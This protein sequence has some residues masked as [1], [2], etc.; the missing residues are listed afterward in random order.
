MNKF[1]EKFNLILE[2]LN[3]KRYDRIN[4]NELFKTLP[5]K[6]QSF[7]KD[8]VDKIFGGCSYRTEERINDKIVEL[9]EEDPINAI[10]AELII[11]GTLPDEVNTNVEL[12]DEE[13]AELD[14]YMDPNFT[15][16][17]ELDISGPNDSVVEETTVRYTVNELFNDLPES[18]KDYVAESVKN[19]QSLDPDEDETEYNEIE[20]E[21][22]RELDDLYEED[23]INAL[24]AQLIIFGTSPEEI[25]TTV[26]LTDEEQAKLEELQNCELT[27][28]LDI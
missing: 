9:Y 6:Y 7:V 22:Y 20:T 13:Q 15:V 23:P 26:E 3:E 2:E 10:K 24:K 1:N 12:T 21:V 14:R 5:E 25:N 19:L 28:Y 18:L 4:V 17:G 8:S 11:F 16:Y 27:G